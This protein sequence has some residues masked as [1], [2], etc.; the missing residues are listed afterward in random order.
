MGGARA[1][2]VKNFTGSSPWHPALVINCNFELRV[3]P[4]EGHDDGM[5]GCLASVV[6]SSFFLKAG[7]R[8]CFYGDSITEQRLYTLYVE[9]FV[10]TRYPGLDISFSCRGW[11]GD[12][13][14]GGG[15]GL[16]EERVRRDVAPLKPTV[17]TVLLGMNDG[18]YSPFDDKVM[19]AFHEW[20]GK[21]LT[22]LD[23][24]KPQPR[25]TLI[26]TS[27][28]DDVAHDFPAYS[29]PPAV[30]HPWHGYNEVLQ[31]Y[32]SVPKSYAASRK[33]T[34]VDFNE[35]LLNALRKAK[36]LDPT[37]AREIIPDAIHP[38]PAGHL[39]MAG[40]LLKVWRVDPLVS[41]LE[42]EVKAGS[43][44]IL[45]SD[46]VKVSA[47]SGSGD[48][49][50]WNSLESSL[51]FC[52]EPE[53]EHIKLALASSHFSEDLNRQVVRLIGLP[54]ENYVLTIDGKRIGTFSSRDLAEGINLALFDT[55]M[56]EQALKVLSF[57]QR[58]SDT[59]FFAWR[60]LDRADQ[61]LKSTNAAVHAVQNMASELDEMARKASVPESHHFV[62]KPAT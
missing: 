38:G 35:P 60:S 31:R 24:L 15:G 61:D 36:Q 20:Y 23:R 11:G 54:N 48:G 4:F 9:A 17:V 55:P 14:W 46:K 44:N 43:P 39:L 3:I 16:P 6:L 49:I 52:V 29:A 21:L 28:W 19:A 56:R 30:W 27:P 58:R 12:A 25:F 1:P 57:C 45:K 13:S 32:G 50:S 53:D 26:R 8:V 33:A 7:D 41:D 34:F 51:P 2:D 18:G 10:R 59:D 42:M 22:E 47:L 37:K 40:E 5:V 62:V